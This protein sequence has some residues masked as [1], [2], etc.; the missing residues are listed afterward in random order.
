[1]KYI[2][3]FA[4][5]GGF[6]LG[7]ENTRRDRLHDKE[8]GKKEPNGETRLGFDCVWANE[9]DKYAC[10]IYRKH[11]G[12][13]DSRDLRD[14]PT[15][16]IPDHDLLVGGF[17]C[18]SF[19][20]AG[21]RGGFEDTRGTM[22]YEI[23]RIANYHQPMFLLLE[24]VKGL[25]SHDKGK[26]LE[27]ILEKLQELGYYT[28]YEVYNSKEY[29]IPQNR[30][31]IF[32]LCTHIKG[33][34]GTNQKIASSRKIITEWLFQVLLNNLSEARKLQG[35]ASK[36]W[37]LGYLICQEIKQS[38]NLKERNIVGGIIPPVESNMSLFGGSEVWR[39]IDTWLLKNLGESSKELNIS[40]ISTAIKRIIASKTY[41]F[42]RMFLAILFAT[43]LL[44]KSSGHLW[45]EVLL[46]L[47][48]IKEGMNY[49][50]NSIQ[51]KEAII[52][53]SGV[54]HFTKNLQD[55]SKYF[56]CGHFGE[57][58]GQAVFPIGEIY[59]VGEGKAQIANTITSNYWKGPAGSRPI[60]TDGMRIRRLT[61]TECE[62]LQGFPGG[63]TEGISD[64]QRYKCLGNAVTVN[65]IEALAGKVK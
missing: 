12:E 37:V 57:S 6:R 16:E 24:N 53:E 5:I 40:T 30:E 23:A 36:D 11:F 48:V 28:N 13:I 62:R 32:F 15:D 46:D 38:Q 8:R 27:I 26:S 1:V 54:M 39:N 33:L 45:S 44:R 22:F 52:T 42:S 43:V 18:Q 35:H 47:M 34:D 21:K 4:G 3:L 29:G 14:V 2:E 7:L 49:A 31:R 51:T 64:T 25:V 9:W 61:P 19:S 65:V 60:P 20:I 63:W 10:Q 58:C 41:T 56:A 55:F 17:P 50:R 59:Q